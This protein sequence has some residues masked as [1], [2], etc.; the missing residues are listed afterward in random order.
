MTVLIVKLSTNKVIEVIAKR[1]SN[2]IE[3]EIEVKTKY[4]A[5]LY[6][7][8]EKD[9]SKKEDDQQAVIEDLSKQLAD[10]RAKLNPEPVKAVDISK[11]PLSTDRLNQLKQLAVEAPM[12]KP[13]WDKELAT[14]TQRPVF[15]SENSSILNEEQEGYSNKVDDAINEI[16]ELLKED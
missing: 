8:A 13:N 10:L 2:W 4:Y 14:L 16:D 11:V 6:E 12:N 5:S 9:T 15:S 7:E 1:N 3:H